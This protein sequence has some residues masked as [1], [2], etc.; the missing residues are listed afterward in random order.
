MSCSLIQPRLLIPVFIGSRLTS[1][2]DP[3]ASHDPLHTWLNILSIGLSLSFSVGTGIF[4]YR[5]TLAQM[6]KLEGEGGRRAAEAL[7]GLEEG[8]LASYTDAMGG[9]EEAAALVVVSPQQ[10]GVGGSEIGEG[11]LKGTVN[12]LKRPAGL[13]RR[14]SS[15]GSE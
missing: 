2:S 12:G 5:A 15:Q 1:L 10:T 14:S 8:L 4:I 3:E 11:A 9:E 6:R 13:Q 7:E